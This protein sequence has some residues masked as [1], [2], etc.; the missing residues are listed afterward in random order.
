MQQS[1]IDIVR[2]KQMCRELEKKLAD[3][4]SELEKTRTDRDSFKKK[5]E[6]KHMQR[7]RSATLNSRESIS[8]S[9]LV[10]RKGSVDMMMMH[11]TG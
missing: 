4:M 2:T 7:A 5:A 8:K 3:L 10:S 11:D 9:N 1:S 6:E